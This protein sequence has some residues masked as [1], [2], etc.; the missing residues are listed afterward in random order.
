MRYFSFLLMA[1]FVLPV[2]AQDQARVIGMQPPKVGAK[3]RNPWPAEYEREFLRRA[4]H[5]IDYY[6]E[7]G[8]SGGTYGEQEKNLYPSAMFGILA[9][10][11][12]AGVEGLQ[13][14][15][16]GPASS[17]TQGIDFYWCFTIKGQTRKYFLFGSM[18]DSDHRKKMFE[19]AKSWT[20]R[21]PLSIRKSLETDSRWGSDWN[22][23]FTGSNVDVRNTDN[24]RAMR[25]TSVYLFAEATGN[26]QTAEI[27]KRRIRDY[28]LALYHIGM[29]EWDSPN[30][31][32]HTLAPYH[33]LYDFAKDPETKLLAK[34]ILDWLYAAGA[35][36]Y[37]NAGWC[38]PS[39]RCYNMRTVVYNDGA[40]HPTSLYFGNNPLTDP[41]PDKDDVYVITSAYRPPP[42]IVELARKRFDKPVE[43]RATK[44]EYD[45]VGYR[46]PFEDWK[47]GD[48]RQP[49]Y[50]E[51]TY[52]GETFQMGSCVS[53]APDVPQEKLGKHDH[54]NVL[55]FKLLAQNS[56]RGADAFVCSIRDADITHAEKQVGEQI[57]QHRNLLI[58]L[59]KGGTPYQFMLPKSAKLSKGGDITFIQLEKTW[60]A[61]RPINM[62]FRGIDRDVTDKLNWQ[63]KKGRR[64]PLYPDEQGMSGRGKGGVL[65]GFALEVGEGVSFAD[66]KKK[67]SSASKL[68]VDGASVTMTGSH[69][70]QLQVIYNTKNDLPTIIRDG[71]TFDYAANLDVYKTVLGPPVITN[72]WHG[73]QLRV[74]AGGKVF[75]GTLELDGT[76]TFTNR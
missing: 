51:T 5:A 57:G 41:H 38:G 46:P 53:D 25:N 26:K 63:E 47:P 18:L 16:A 68:A 64:E 29:T 60:L 52:I 1:V 39:A 36:K 71:E 9:G 72:A 24:L 23:S 65:S 66:F 14:G 55:T 70:A 31:L 74:E 50:W 33:N 58:Y 17:G 22:P 27:Y 10:N 49:K 59:A 73:G 54:W 76:Y 20:R 44:P 75:E 6:R 42:A 43:I 37:Y 7:K 34:A 69:G 62:D 15:S 8:V 13:K 45:R 4:E 40:A 48:D 3:Y 12:A 61:L 30:Y 67:V 11:K 35:V 19:G 21:D 28:A 32:G 56:K 2:V